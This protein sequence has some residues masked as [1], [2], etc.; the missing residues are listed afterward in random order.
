M[1]QRGE[2]N[3]LV[4]LVVAFTLSPPRS[5]LRVIHESEL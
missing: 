4:A 2:K 3:N 5:F 1:L